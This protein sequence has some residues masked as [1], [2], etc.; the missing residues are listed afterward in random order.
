MESFQ[1]TFASTA[2]IAAKYHGPTPSA[3]V[4]PIF[5]DDVGE[6]KPLLRA[7][8]GR[9]GTGVTIYGVAGFLDAARSRAATPMQ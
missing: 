5:L 9:P 2:M 4:Q 6:D 3:T 8:A 1:T 7:I